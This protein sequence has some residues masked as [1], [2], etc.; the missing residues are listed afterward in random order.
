MGLQINNRETEKQ[1]AVKSKIMFD[2][3]LQKTVEWYKNNKGF[4]EKQMAMRKV[5]VKN[6]KGEIIW[7]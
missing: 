2:T 5:P 3:G 7:Y 4:W 6:K 1:L